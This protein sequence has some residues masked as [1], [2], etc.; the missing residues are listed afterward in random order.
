MHVGL[1]I[2]YFDSSSIHNILKI[3]S[4]TAYIKTFLSPCI[5]VSEY[6]HSQ[7]SD[8]SSISSF[9]MFYYTIINK[10]AYHCCYKITAIICV[11]SFT[12]FCLLEGLTTIL[13]N[14]ITF[15]GA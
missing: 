5:F 3:I 13:I 7:R 14:I 4:D 6:Q 10:P 1:S 15:H 2:R 11:D 12:F 9:L 8:V